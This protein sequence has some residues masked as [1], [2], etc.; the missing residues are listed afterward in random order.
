MTDNQRSDPQTTAM[1]R[2]RRALDAPD[3]LMGGEAAVMRTTDVAALLGAIDGAYSIL[4]SGN[5]THSARESNARNLL[6]LAGAKM[7]DRT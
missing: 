7:K 4:C 3:S 2:V 1:G 6:R 5:P